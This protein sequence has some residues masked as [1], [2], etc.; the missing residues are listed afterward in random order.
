MQT[1]SYGGD[2][3]D[4]TTR[5][6]TASS[7]PT[8]WLRGDLASSALIHFP[9]YRAP[10]FDRSW[11]PFQVPPLELARPRSELPDAEL[12]TGLYELLEPYQRMSRSLLKFGDV[13][14]ASS[15]RFTVVQLAR[16]I[17]A[18]ECHSVERFKKMV[19]EVTGRVIRSSE[20]LTFPSRP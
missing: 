13:L 14:C 1:R 8:F 6:S 15:Y 11:R 18:L 12:L 17:T 16:S 2:S 20:G 7:S 4:G 10:S 3:K 9:V 19:T 5:Y